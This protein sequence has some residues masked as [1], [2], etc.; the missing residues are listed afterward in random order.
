MKINLK[1]VQLG[2]L[3]LLIVSVFLNISLIKINRDMTNRY[4]NA[5]D[6]MNEK[7]KL[8]ILKNK[9]EAKESIEEK[10]RAD[11]VSYEALSK[12]A[13][14]LREE[15]VILKSQV[16]EQQEEIDSLEK[17]LKKKRR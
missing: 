10:Y 3:L 16:K 14:M 8:A 6:I 7:L 12:R 2:V 5:S 11:M 4:E 17:Q 13:Q 15:V 1:A 9:E